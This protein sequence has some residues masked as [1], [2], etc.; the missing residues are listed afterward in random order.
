MC[1]CGGGRCSAYLPRHRLQ[2]SAP[3][4][5]RRKPP[6]GPGGGGGRPSSFPRKEA[7][8][9]SCDRMRGDAPSPV[10]GDFPGRARFA[11]ELL[12][13][14]RTELPPVVWGSSPPLHPFGELW[15]DPPSGRQLK[16]HISPEGRLRGRRDSLGVR[17]G[18][19]G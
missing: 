12:P 17:G 4:T 9:G 13:R 5:W 7:P 15:V 10:A 16:S 2:P 6:G 8:G 1:V 18:R 3:A 19:W 14:G 11:R